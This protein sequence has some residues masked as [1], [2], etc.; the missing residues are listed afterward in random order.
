MKKVSFAIDLSF[1]KFFNEEWISVVV[2]ERGLDHESV[3]RRMDL[4]AMTHAS[5]NSSL[6]SATN[7]TKG[8]VKSL[9][10]EMMET[11][12]K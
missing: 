2:E 7:V 12:K 3:D 10:P 1:L 5:S 6:N 11:K 8:I 4:L 9:T